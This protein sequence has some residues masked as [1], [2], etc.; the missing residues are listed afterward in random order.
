VVLE[1]ANHVA[2]DIL[3]SQTGAEALRHIADAAR[4]LTQ[5]RY[6][7]LGVARLD[8]NGLM[9]FVTV[10]LTAEEE[11]QIGSRPQGQGLLGLLLQRTEPLRVD[12]LAAHSASSGFP[13]NHPPM[14]SFLACLFGAAIRCSAAST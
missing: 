7:A 5:A 8:G 4:R 1:A 11:A 2:L 6:A 9:E 3:T 14:D 12:T 13:P 10:G